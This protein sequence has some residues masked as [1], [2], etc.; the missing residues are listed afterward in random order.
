MIRIVG[1]SSPSRSGSPDDC[2]AICLVL[3]D[4][5]LPGGTHFGVELPADLGLT[6]P[7][8]DHVHIGVQHLPAPLNP[9][10]AEMLG[11]PLAVPA[12]SDVPSERAH[13]SVASF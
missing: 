5:L 2:R 12:G 9:P 13:D 10:V 8:L 7:L 3:R 11:Q 4:D 6:P 1:T